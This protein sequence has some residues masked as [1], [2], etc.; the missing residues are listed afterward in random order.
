MGEKVSFFRSAAFESLCLAVFGFCFFYFYQDIDSLRDWSWWDCSSW[1][2]FVAFLMVKFFWSCGERVCTGRW[3][4]VDRRREGKRKSAL[5][6]VLGWCFVISILVTAVV[7]RFKY[8]GPRE[9]IDGVTWRYV[10][11]DG[12]AVIE[13]HNNSHGRPSISVTTSGALEIPSVLGGYP[14]VGIGRDAFHGCD[15]LTAVSIPRSLTKV[16]GRP[17]HPFL[18]ANIRTVYVAKG[19]VERV[20]SMAG[21]LCIM[22]NSEKW[23]FGSNEAKF[24]ECDE[25]PNP[26]GKDL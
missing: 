21:E 3:S 16:S 1:I 9:V 26:P 7:L 6:R 22:V 13:R 11:K 10:V 18:G 2:V 20:K 14:V 4:A 5:V 12:K 19:D 8:S 24:V 23:N 25:Y 15:Q 17:G